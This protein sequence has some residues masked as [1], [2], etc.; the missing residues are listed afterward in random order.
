MEEGRQVINTRT[1]TQTIEYGRSYKPIME[2]RERRRPGWRGFISI[3]GSGYETY[4][5]QTGSQTII[6]WRKEQREVSTLR[7]GIEQF[8]DWRVIDTWST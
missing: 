3:D 4:E 1:D 5:V 8:G 2:T 6:H 7:C